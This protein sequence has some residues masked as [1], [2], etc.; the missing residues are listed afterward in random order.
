MHLS[1]EPSHVNGEIWDE[2]HL[3]LD[4]VERHLQLLRSRV[5]SLSSAHAQISDE[6]EATQR[7]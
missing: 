3:Q 5:S 6:P 7:Q 1:Q 4:D 2:F